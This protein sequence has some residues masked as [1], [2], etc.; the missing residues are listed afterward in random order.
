MTPEQ[1]YQSLHEGAGYVAT[2]RDVVL[3]TG[4]DAQEYLN[5]QLS[6]DVAALPVASETAA[7]AYTFL[8]QP[9]GKVAAFGQLLKL[10][11]EQFALATPLG[12][13]KATVERLERF[14]LRVDCELSQETWPCY[15]YV[16]ADT[17]AANSRWGGVDILGPQAEPPPGLSQLPSQVWEVVRVEAGIPELGREVLPDAIPAEVGK[18][19]LEQSVSFTKG[20]YVG[21][22]L[23]E[24]MHAR[25]SGAPK[26]LMGVRF[27]DDSPAELPVGKPMELP[28]GQ[29]TSWVDSP[30]FG[31]IG[32]ALLPRSL[33]P[34]G[35]LATDSG[36]KIEI[37]ELPFGN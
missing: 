23:V 3:V 36:A 28:E 1:Q 30:S 24:R 33:E 11:D 8:L 25:G 27:P 2:E 9:T 22:E 13:G 12:W 7:T 21:Q 6:Q 16:P 35:E 32:L 10:A 14:L 37:C 19:W 29:L 18:F 5:G 26:R 31:T 34:G 15:G 17:Q 4:A 20:C